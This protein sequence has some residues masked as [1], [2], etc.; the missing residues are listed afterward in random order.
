MNHKTLVL[1]LPLLI[2]MG[3]TM[4]VTSVDR[5]PV[6]LA[7]ANTEQPVYFHLLSNR[8]V[9]ASRWRTGIAEARYSIGSSGSFDWIFNTGDPSAEFL[10]VAEFA[11]GE[12]YSSR[13]AVLGFDPVV[14]GAV[15]TAH[16]VQTVY[17]RGEDLFS[18]TA[19]ASLFLGSTGINAP[20]GPFIEAQVTHYY[21]YSGDKP[22]RVDLDQPI[23]VHQLID[24]APWLR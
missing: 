6:K 9:V 17:P 21:V 16:H 4:Y 2:N 5:S 1:L 19:A 12:T 8:S 15:S 24:A 22:V 13:L 23:T 10:Q 18:P 14:I 20:I 11:L 7:G 3:C